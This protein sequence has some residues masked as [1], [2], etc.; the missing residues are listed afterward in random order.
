MVTQELFADGEELPPVE[1]L[2]EGSDPL[3]A[4]SYTYPRL[5]K[6]FEKALKA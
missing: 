5:D 3:V 1:S 6:I 4:S 2:P